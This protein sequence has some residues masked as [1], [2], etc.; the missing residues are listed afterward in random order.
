MHLLES[1]PLSNISCATLHVIL[2]QRLLLKLG[3]GLD[4]SEAPSWRV[5]SDFFVS[6]FGLYGKHHLIFRE[7][8]QMTLIFVSETA[9][10]RPQL[11]EV[12]LLKFDGISVIHAGLL[13]VIGCRYDMLH[14]GPSIHR[15][16]L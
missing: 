5:D 4:N 7:L 15:H 9:I 1:A 6:T 12:A 2:G 13:V 11:D 16:R 14:G 10:G 8:Y 3:F